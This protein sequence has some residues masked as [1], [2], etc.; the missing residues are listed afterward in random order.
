MSKDVSFVMDL[1]GGQEILTNMAAAQ[2]K[3]S[4]D[5]IAQRAQSM[6]GS[7]SSDP[8]EITVSTKIGTIR[9]GVRAIAT[10]TANGRDEHQTYIG[11]M[12]LTKAKDAG[13]I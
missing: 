2:V 4:A 5:A 9:K 7:M 10:I 6:A 1:V 8:P 11:A 3:A 12:A 13:R